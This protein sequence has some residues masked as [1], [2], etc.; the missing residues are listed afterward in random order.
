MLTCC[1]FTE[2]TQTFLSR[3][4]LPQFPHTYIIILFQPNFFKVHTKFI[5]NFLFQH[6]KTTCKYFQAILNLTWFWQKKWLDWMWEAGSFP[7]IDLL[8]QNSMATLGSYRNLKTRWVAFRFTLPKNYLELYH[9]S[10]CHR[11][12]PQTLWNSFELHAGRERRSS[13]ISKAPSAVAQRSDFLR[14]RKVDRML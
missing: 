11:P 5:N 9:Y 7:R 14:L 4:F 6:E 8:W 12:V 1:L 13:R 10:Y 2:E 3:I